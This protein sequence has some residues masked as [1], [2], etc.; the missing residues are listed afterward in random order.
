MTAKTYSKIKIASPLKYLEQF[1]F[2]FKMLFL[3]L[4]GKEIP[5]KEDPNLMK[6]Y[7]SK[8]RKNKKENNKRGLLT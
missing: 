8:K 7:K 3:P 2:T 1:N 5:L 4:S 6:K